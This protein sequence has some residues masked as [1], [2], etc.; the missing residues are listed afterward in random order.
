[1]QIHI[2]PVSIGVFL[3]VAPVAVCIIVAV[4]FGSLVF[5]KEIHRCFTGKPCFEA[6]EK[7]EWH[8]SMRSHCKNNPET[9]DCRRYYAKYGK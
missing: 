5:L 3:A 6:T 7:L 1:M 4:W 2:D 9:T 8:Q